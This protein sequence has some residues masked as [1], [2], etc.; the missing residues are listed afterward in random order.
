MSENCLSLRIA[1][2]P[3]TRPGAKSPVAVW[4]H[5][6]GHALG[7]AY[8]VL[9]EPDGLV[10]QAAADGQPLIFVAINY[11]L[12]FFGFATSQAL[13]KT[14]HTNAG[15]RD[16][17]AA[18]EWVR[19]NIESFGGDPRR[20]Q[21]IGASDISLQLAAFGGEHG[22]P[23][24][25][26]IMMSGAPGLNFNTKSDLVA[27]N[28]AAVA[29][30]VG[31]VQNGESCSQET[32]K[33]L[34]EAHADMLANLSVTASRAAR[35]PFGEGFFY[36][37]YD[38]DFLPDR[39]SQLVRSGRVNKG[40]P[41]IASWVTN[42]G[43]WYAPPT[44]SSDEEVLASFGLWLTGLTESTKAKLLQLYPTSDFE[45]MVR[46]EWAGVSPQY[47]RAA[48]LNRDLWFTC[49]VLDFAWQYGKHN[50]R[51]LRLYEHNST[52]FTPAY[53]V[54]GVPMWRVAHLSDIPYVLNEQR[55]VAAPTTRRR[56]WTCPRS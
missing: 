40:V 16:Q 9:Y 54:M 42:D 2:P 45:H 11:R 28:T 3:G 25:R 23:F 36:P 7:S 14:K 20:G 4:L 52:R 31:C 5:G 22:V 35:P 1:R 49:P 24:Q 29:Q 43:A 17:R 33:C 47:Y 21:S 41:V 12:G 6:G 55:L 56:S 15:L 13:V 51:Q 38:G 19:D 46:P 44:T 50:Y 8:E 37:T 53:E 32:L 39:P 10:R 48:Q 26:A 27:N 30:Q 18:L 34:R